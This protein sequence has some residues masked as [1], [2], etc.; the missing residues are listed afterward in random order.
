MHTLTHRGIHSQH[1]CIWMRVHTHHTQTRPSATSYRH[2]HTCIS[3]HIHTERHI[4]A[5]TR[6][7]I[8]TGT[9][10]YA[11]RRAHTNTDAHTWQP[12]GVVMAH[13]DHRNSSCFAQTPGLSPQ[14]SATPEPVLIDLNPGASLKLLLY[15]IT[16]CWFSWLQIGTGPQR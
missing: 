11:C 9:H 13:R 8:H 15:G 7:D 5:P 4:P 1:T 12:P 16:C 6:S 10:A 2:T 14:A 3:M